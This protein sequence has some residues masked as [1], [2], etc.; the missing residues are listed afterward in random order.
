MPIWAAIGLFLAGAAGTAL[1]LRAYFH[2]GGRIFL[3][4]G[5]AAALLCAAALLYC[6]LALFLVSSIE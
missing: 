3:A 4:A 1:S 6:G 2:G 5:A